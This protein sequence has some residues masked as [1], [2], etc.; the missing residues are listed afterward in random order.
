MKWLII[1]VVV[2]VISYLVWPRRQVK[3][4]GR[5]SDLSGYLR[6]LMTANNP[7]AFLVV[8]FPG[9]SHFIQFNGDESGVQL[10]MPLIEPDQVLLQ[11]SL[12][13]VC[14][15]EGLIPQITKG[16]DGTEFFDCKID[17]KIE[18]VVS[19]LENIIASVFGVKKDDKVMYTLAGFSRGEAP[20][21][22]VQQTGK[23]MAFLV[24]FVGI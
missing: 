1:V 12:E 13:A 11:S 16:S 21:L 19:A 18:D 6:G 4:R 17:G 22:A 9:F 8:D 14:R 24:N 15:G 7:H 5:V 23:A 10:D 3:V 20:N 2:L